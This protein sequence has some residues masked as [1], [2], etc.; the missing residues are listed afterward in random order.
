MVV[1]CT[2]EIEQEIAPTS[3]MSA[4]MIVELLAMPSVVGS[5]NSSKSS[6]TSRCL[7]MIVSHVPVH[8]PNLFNGLVA[9]DDTGLKKPDMPWL[10]S[11]EQLVA[12]SF[13]EQILMAENPAGSL[14]TLAQLRE[15]LAQAVTR[16]EQ[17][18]HTARL[19]CLRETAAA[20][21]KREP[22]DLLDISSQR[23]GTFVADDQHNAR[24]QLKRRAQMAAR[25]ERGS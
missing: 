13:E 11:V 2:H 19:E 14:R 24:R 10:A 12:Q 22:L 21:G 7:E 18:D 17:L 16:Y 5:L 23:A 25:D 8:W 15:L 20:L 4:D 9:S 6:M 3:K 1:K